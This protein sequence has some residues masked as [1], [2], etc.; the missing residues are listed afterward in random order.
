V[1]QVVDPHFWQVSVLLDRYPEPADFLNRL[2]GG[3]APAKA[4]GASAAA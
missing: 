1:A 3:R 2:A 4:G